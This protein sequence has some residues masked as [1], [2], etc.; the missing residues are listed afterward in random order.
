M[1]VL[2]L[3]S[4]LKIKNLT[5]RH[6]E[7]LLSLYGLQSDLSM[8]APC[9]CPMTAGKEVGETVQEELSLNIS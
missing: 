1:F 8:V 7:R 2:R 5:N 9:L 3:K 6:Y 4:T